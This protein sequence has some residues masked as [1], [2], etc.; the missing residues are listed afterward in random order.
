[1][2][3]LKNRTQGSYTITSQ[4]ITRDT[5][6]SLTERGMLLT[7]LSLPD[8]WH[9]T[10]N[11]LKK[12]LPDGKDRISNTLNSLIEKG[13]VTRVQSRGS[14][15]KFSSTDLE[16]HESPVPRREK[17]PDS[18]EDI[19]PCPE[20]PDAVKPGAGNP[21]QSKTYTYNT[22]PSTSHRV[23]EEDT[24]SE[25]D[26][27]KLVSEFGTS[28]VE[29]QIKRI[30]SHCYKGCM[31][32][33]TIRSWCSERA[34]RPST[35]HNTHDTHDTY[36]THDTHNIPKNRHGFFDFPQRTYDYDE[37]EKKLFFV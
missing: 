27:D 14:M 16:V 31:N 26:Y 12:I 6:L 19:P 23:C 11:G 1:M 28:S 18:K 33:E 8:N 5:N 20:N 15:G 30:R 34:N 2:A 4:T 21:I 37:L 22:S 32:Y 9:L 24:L 7:L 29:Y 13:Y 36:N 25:T 17:K 35:T 10:I 3:V